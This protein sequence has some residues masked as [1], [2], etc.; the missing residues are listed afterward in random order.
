MNVSAW[1]RKNLFHVVAGRLRHPWPLYKKAGGISAVITREDGTRED[2]GR[3][4]VTYLKRS[5][6]SVGAK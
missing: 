2:L 5:G 1:K 3:V 6:W 4:S